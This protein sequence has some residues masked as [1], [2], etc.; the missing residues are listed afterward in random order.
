[1]DTF[2]N[3]VPEARRAAVEGCLRKR[4]SCVQVSLSK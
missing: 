4:T 1:M 2:S 3:T